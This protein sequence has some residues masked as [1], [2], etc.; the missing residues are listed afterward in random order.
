V[1]YAE[2]KGLIGADDCNE[3]F[4]TNLKGDI[5][6]KRSLMIFTVAQLCVGFALAGSWNPNPKMVKY[7]QYGRKTDVSPNYDYVQIGTTDS[8]GWTYKSTCSTCSVDGVKSIMS[9]AL[10]AQATGE[11]LYFSTISGSGHSFEI[12]AI[13][14]GANQ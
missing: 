4:L 14:K 1:G 8:T 12:D 7:V 13:S 3:L 10:S 11:D 6:M 5:N 9:V 2:S